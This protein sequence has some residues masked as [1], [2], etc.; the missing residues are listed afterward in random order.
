ME[1]APPFANHNDNHYPSRNLALFYQGSLVY[2]VCHGLELF[3]AVSSFF[4]LGRFYLGLALCQ[5]KSG[6]GKRT[7]EA[8]KYLSEG[9]EH[10][11]KQMS[12]ESNEPIKDPEKRPR[13]TCLSSYNLLRCDNVQWLQGCALLA[14]LCKKMPT[15]PPGVMSA[16]SALHLSGM[17]SSHVLSHLVARGDT[18]HQVEWVLFETH[19]TLLQM[20]L[21]ETKDKGDGKHVE[22]SC[23]CENLSGLLNYSNIPPGKQILDLQEKVRM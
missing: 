20:M 22:I 14:S 13:Q 21:E 9:T 23:F 18:Y 10:L 7:Q 11:L 3:D 17:L 5:Q 8:V 6:P 2:S 1:L 4:G 19:F 12:T 15:T 16:D